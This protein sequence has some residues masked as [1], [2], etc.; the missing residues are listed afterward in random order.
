MQL[1]KE[2]ADPT[3]LAATGKS[4]VPLI[5][6]RNRIKGLLVVEESDQ[7]HTSSDGSAESPE[8]ANEGGGDTLTSAF[9]TSDSAISFLARVEDECERVSAEERHSKLAAAYRMVTNHLGSAGGSKCLDIWLRYVQFQA[10]VAPADARPSARPHDRNAQ[11]R[12]HQRRCHRTR[13][14]CLRAAALH[15]GSPVSARV[16]AQGDLRRRGAG[17]LSAHRRCRGR[18]GRP[19]VLRLPRT[20]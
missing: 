18:R 4:A 16:M 9:F 5:A 17:Y 3:R 12:A 10:C 13:S 1:D 20:V 6:L 8:V 7:A 19:A 15:V 14:P 11:P 2:N